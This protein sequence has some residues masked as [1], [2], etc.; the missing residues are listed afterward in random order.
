MFVIGYFKSK[1]EAK[2]GKTKYEELLS[3][4]FSRGHDDRN[5]IGFGQRGLTCNVLNYL[6]KLFI[7]D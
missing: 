5:A 3:C 2:N 1:D 7:T 4:K 6:F